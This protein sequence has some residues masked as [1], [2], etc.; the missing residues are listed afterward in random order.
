MTNFLLMDD[1]DP[2]GLDSSSS[3]AARYMSLIGKIKNAKTNKEWYDKAYEKLRTN[4]AL[5]EYA[6]DSRGS[7]I[8][9]DSSGDFARFNA[10]QIA[11]GAIGDYRILTNSELLDIRANTSAAPF[12]ANII[13]QAANGVSMEQINDHISK[14]IQGLG[15]EK[16]Q[17]QIF[18][19]QSKDVMAGLRQLQEAAKEVGQDLSISQ[20]YE[21]N[22]FTESQASQA[23]LALKYIYSTLPTNMKALLFAKAGSMAGVEDLIRT[24]VNSKLSS[25]TKLEFSP[26]TNGSR[27]S[28]KKTGNILI[29]GLELSPAQMLQQ[30]YGERESVLIQNNSSG[31]L[32]VEAI[33][34][35]VTKEG[36][37]PVGATTLEG[38]AASQFGGL[39]NFNNASMGGKIIPFE[40]R[41]NIAVDGSKMYSMYLP[42]DQEE[43]ATKGNIIPDIALIDKVNAVNKT[44]KEKQITDPKIID[45]LRRVVEVSE[46]LKPKIDI[47]YSG[48]LFHW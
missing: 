35:P 33:T 31:G 6:V 37:Q 48:Q 38:V 21:A 5:N 24:L 8:G 13:M 10:K 46:R 12:D 22:I 1:M 30:G 9:M 16:H 3:I 44:I 39:L 4:G 36:N 32:Y 23:K 34:M 26:K 14:I 20:L 25:T 7:F 47:V 15:S 29:D 18:G 17:T 2:L 41:R 45:Y 28:T 40:G 11:E 19:D 43:Y 42:I 27:S